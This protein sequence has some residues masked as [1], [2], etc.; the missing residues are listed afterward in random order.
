MPV[1]L[2]HLMI[3]HHLS[4]D[5]LSIC[6]IFYLMVDAI[7]IPSIYS[8]ESEIHVNHSDFYLGLV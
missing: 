4:I 6:M 7:V 8:L 3:N 1:V 2:H 5:H